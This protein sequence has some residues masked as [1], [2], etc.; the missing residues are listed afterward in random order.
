M[1]QIKPAKEAQFDPILTKLNEVIEVVNQL[2]AKQVKE[3]KS[4]NKTA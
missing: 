2:I 1:N 3:D 4:E